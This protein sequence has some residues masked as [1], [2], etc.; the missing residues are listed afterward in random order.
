MVGQGRKKWARAAVCAAAL[1]TPLAVSGCQSGTNAGGAGSGATS[2]ASGTPVASSSPAT[3]TSSSGRST[4]ASSSSSTPSP[5]PSELNATGGTGLTV[6]DGSSKVLMNGQAVD[7]GTAVHDP[8]WSPD[9]KR[10]VFIDGGG[11][12][13]VAKADGTGRT[14]V[15]KNPGGQKWSHPTWQTRKA[16]PVNQVPALNAFFFA[17]TVDGTTT[18]KTVTVDAHD[19]KPQELELNGYA[20]ENAALP[21]PTGNKWPSAAGQLG[22]AVYEHDN[23]SGSDVYV[24][25]DYLR[26]Q[27]GLS[28]KNAA[29]PGYVLLGKTSTGEETPEVVFVRA[30][31]GHRHVFLSSLQTSIGGDRPAPKDLTPNATTDCVEPAISSDGKTVAFS[32]PSGVEIVPADGSKAPKLVTSVPGFPAFRAG[33]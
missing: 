7:F 30:V 25:D 19:G 24:R 22:A 16:D 13:V 5:A 12:L 3:V 21:P 14:E 32:T 6:S 18:L 9:G 2:G 8:S 17:S 27:G 33:S 4:A 23:G 29:Q 31:N 11:N 28:I 15:A 1:M 20:D 26:Q 10:V